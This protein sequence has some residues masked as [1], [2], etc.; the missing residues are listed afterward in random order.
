MRK[1]VILLVALGLLGSGAILLWVSSFRIPDLNTFDERIIKQSTK[2]YDRTGEILLFDIHENVQRTT[3]PY[4]EI[5]RNI[6]NATVAIEDAEFY[7]HSGV[8]PL[9][10]FRAVFL[11]PLRGKGVQGGS[12]ITQQVIKNSLLTSEVK[13]SRKLKEWVLSFK[14]EKVLSKNEI[15]SIYLNEAPYGGNIYGIEEASG[16]FFNKSAADLTL[17]ESAYLAAL[18]QAPTFFSPYGNNR[19]RLDSRKNL[20]LERMAVN[21]F[22][23]EQE[24]E[25]ASQEEVE[26][27]PRSDQSLKAP[28]FV[29]YVRE[30]LETKYGQKVIEEDGLR[31]ITTLNYDL[32]VKAEEIVKRRALDNADKF[33]AENAAL[34]AVD[35]KTGQ[36]L[37]MVGSRDYF[38][39]DIDGNFNVTLAH[40]QPGSAFKPFVYATAFKK[41][42]TPETIVFDVETEFSSTCDSLGKPLAGQDPETCYRPVNYDSKFRGPITLRNALAQSVNIPAIKVLYL[43]GITD[44]IRTARDHKSS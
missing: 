38:D 41:G 26:F 37:T 25:K 17:A 8:R 9:A 20:V 15:L 39:E 7:V 23:T 36:I 19:E 29:Q 12:T 40:R 44:S 18:P 3:V 1:F 22:I 14:L 43:V 28:H 5:S 4:E 31:V 32:Q 34:V 2:I 24:K 27:I 42:Y 35:P 6:K 21:G 11:Q 33:D 16:R 30:Y 13:I 10:T